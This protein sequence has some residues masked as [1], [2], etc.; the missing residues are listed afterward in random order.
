MDEAKALNR[1]ASM[2]SMAQRDQAFPVVHVGAL[3]FHRLGGLF[4]DSRYNKSMEKDLI[5][6]KA[7]SDQYFDL[8]AKHPVLK[9]IFALGNRLIFV[10]E[11][12]AYRVQSD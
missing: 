6:V 5:E 1:L 12:K 8:L 2:G 4:V 9:K 7:Y 11:G 3:V 10:L